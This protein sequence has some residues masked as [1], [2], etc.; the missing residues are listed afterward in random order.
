MIKRLIKYLLHLKP[1]EKLGRVP[2]MFATE[3]KSFS[4]SDARAMARLGI[5]SPSGLKSAMRK[6]RVNSVDDLIDRLDHHKPK[7]HVWRRLRN[8]FSRWA[9]GYDYVPHRQEIMRAHKTNNDLLL[10]RREEVAKSYKHGIP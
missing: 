1:K 5:R 10:K 6:Y 7:R 4:D 2:N 8:I 3:F 9:G